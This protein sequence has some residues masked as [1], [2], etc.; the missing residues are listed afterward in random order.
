MRQRALDYLGKREYSY[1][2]L[3]KKLKTFA[4]ETDEIAAILDDFKTRGWLSD[5][6]FTE[7]LVHARQSKFGSARVANEL[8]EKGVADDLIASAVEAIKVNELEHARAICRKKYK[9]SPKSRED[10]ARQAR[11]LQSRGFGFDVIKKALND[12]RDEPNNEP[13]NE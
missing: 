12:H 9:E 6:R 13:S 2:E 10:W 4:E 5:A 1:V 7:Q 11:F 3:G 8:R